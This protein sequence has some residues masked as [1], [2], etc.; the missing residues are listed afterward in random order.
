MNDDS[1]LKKFETKKLRLSASKQDLIKAGEHQAEKYPVAKTG[2]YKPVKRDVVKM[3]TAEESKMIPELLALRHQR[4]MVNAFTFLRGTAGIMEYDLMQNKHSDIPVMICGDAHLNNFGFFASPERQLLFGLNDFDET[5]VGNWENDLKRLMVSAKLIGEINDYNEDDNKKILKKTAKSYHAGIGYANSLE[6]MQRFYTSYNIEDFLKFV[7]D[8]KQMTQILEHVAKIAPHNNSEKVI[9]KFT[10][11]QDGKIVF[12]SNPPRA[13]K[14]NDKTYS[15]LI[16]AYQQYLQ[17]LT[18]DM[19][20]FLSNFQVTDIIRYSVGV[21]SFG[22]RCYL[23][24]LTGKDKSHLVLQIKEAMPSKYDL[25]NLSIAQAKEQGYE[26]GRRVITGQRILQTFYD[27][28]LGYT[29]T[30]TRSYYVRQFRDMKDSI[31][32]TKLDKKSFT[33]YATLCAFILGM[34]HYNSPTAPMIYGYLE[35]SKNFAE[36]FANWT[37][38]YSKQVHQDYLAFQKYLRGE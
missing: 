9:K 34:A 24:L 27:P 18:P 6:L 1:S 7:N 35:N 29:K 13:R 4:M 36:N 15:E 8:D 33:A 12:K 25:I 26:A 10:C 20:V 11:V 19:Q 22:T 37:I 2:E 38:A 5:R 14:V 30:N 32:S 23:V 3:I 21:G 17:N 28:F 16:L 31:D